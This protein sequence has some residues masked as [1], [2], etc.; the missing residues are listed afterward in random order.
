MYNVTRCWSLNIINVI[1]TIIA[2]CN[3]VFSVLTF[4]IL[5]NSYIMFV[6]YRWFVFLGSF[7]FNKGCSR[8]KFVC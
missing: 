4:T 8:I 2:I 1:V 7:D 3:I 6:F 5:S